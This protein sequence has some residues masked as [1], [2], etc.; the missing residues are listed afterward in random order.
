M[1]KLFPFHFKPTSGLLSS[2]DKNVSCQKAINKK[3][4]RKTPERYKLHPFKVFIGLM[5][6]QSGNYPVVSS[7]R[8]L[9]I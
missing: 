4:T 6:K 2:F 5:I 1:Y 9:K 7:K 3:L 8:S